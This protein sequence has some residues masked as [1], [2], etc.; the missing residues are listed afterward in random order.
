MTVEIRELVI[1]TNIVSHPKP[2]A[3]DHKLPNLQL[4]KQQVVAECLKVLRDKQP[5]NSFNR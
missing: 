2:D 1:K 4:L 3:A 5:K